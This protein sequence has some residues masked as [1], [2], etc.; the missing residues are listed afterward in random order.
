MSSATSIEGVPAKPAAD[1]SSFKPWHFFVLASLMAATVA[2]L[3]SRRS[4]PEHLVLISLAIGAAG[5]AAAGFY[6]MLAPLVSD[7]A[8]TAVSSLSDRVRTALEREK[9]LTLRSIKELEFDRAMGK[10]SPKD[11]DEMAGRLRARAITLM[12]E[13]DQGPTAYR[14]AIERELSERLAKKSSEPSA[15]VHPVCDACGAANDLDAAYCK[16]CGSKLAAVAGGAA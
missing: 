14:A 1:D 11:F 16:K 5:L 6:R 13:L 9:A 12:R 8:S 7:E 2:V 4:T 3:M 10:V 15:P